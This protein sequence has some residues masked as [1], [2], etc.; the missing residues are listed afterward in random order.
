MRPQSTTS[1]VVVHGDE[2]ERIGRQ[3]VARRAGLDGIVAGAPSEVPALVAGADGPVRIVLFV[4]PDHRRWDRYAAI[5]E[6]AEAAATVAATGGRPWA[7]VPIV[8]H[9]VNPL[10]KLRLQRLG[11]STAISKQA[12]TSAQGW[13]DVL[14]GAIEGDDITRVSHGLSLLAVGRRSDPAAALRWIE[15]KGWESAFRPG[16]TQGS[17]GLTRR[18]ALHL[19]R[20][21]TRLGD[22]EV[23]PAR[24]GGGPD[25]NVGLPFW[26]DVVDFVNVARGASPTPWASRAPLS[27]DAASV[28]VTRM[29]RC[30]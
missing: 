6:V 18:Q 29:G 11:A 12:V 19:R 1:T 23:P 26:R 5:E 24:W 15:Q 21:V 10:V 4:T 14:T 17:S 13:I 28:D 8:D 20:E 9:R 7:L 30:G 3:E 22:L 16:V 25:R 2:I 27:G